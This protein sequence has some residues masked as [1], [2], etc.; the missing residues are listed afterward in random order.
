MM[1]LTR[2][3]TSNLRPEAIID[4]AEVVSLVQLNT[5]DSADVVGLV[6]ANSLDS[7]AVSGLINTGLAGGSVG[8]GTITSTNFAASTSL[9]IYNSAGVPVKTIYSPGS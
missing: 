9:I 6:L 4:S 1:T 2:L 8:I 5:F 3:R 7:A